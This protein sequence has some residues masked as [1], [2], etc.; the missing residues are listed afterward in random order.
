MPV[1]P[2]SHLQTP[3][4]RHLPRPLQLLGHVPVKKSNLELKANQR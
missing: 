3:L 1:Y 4:K 2:F